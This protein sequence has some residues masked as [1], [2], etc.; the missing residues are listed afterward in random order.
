MGP[1]LSR[2]LTATFVTIDITKTLQ[3]SS[4][5]TLANFYPSDSRK[6]SEMLGK[7]NLPKILKLKLETVILTENGSIWPYYFYRIFQTVGTLLYKHFVHI[8]K[9]TNEV[10]ME[11]IDIFLGF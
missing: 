10:G 1:V 11:P 8:E 3:P 5:Q 6:V 2:S 9:R 7:K 4:L